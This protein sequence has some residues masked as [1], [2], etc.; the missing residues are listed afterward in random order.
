[1]GRR[2]APSGALTPTLASR[3][4]TAAGLLG[5]FLA[6]L[7]FFPY[8][9]WTALIASAVALAA[10]EWGA[11]AGAAAV[12]RLVYAL[13]IGALVALLGWTGA[14]PGSPIPWAV[15][16]AATLFWLVA[17]PA[18]F[19]RGWPRLPLPVLLGAGAL[20]LVPAGVAAVVLRGGSPAELL[21]VLAAVWVADSAAYLVGR[22]W[23][24]RKLAP[25]ISPG[26]TW[27]GL[28]GALVA[29]ALGAI[30]VQT[31][32]AVRVFWA[33]GLWITLLLVALAAVSVLGDLFESAVKRHA[34][35][36]DSGTLLP[37]HGGVLDR[38]DSLT[39]AL[40]VAGLLAGLARPIGGP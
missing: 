11:L 23:G 25:V 40:P 24:R 29:V 28:M 5:L 16:T 37:G 17:V 14:G 10:W 4:L 9:A 3:V 27:E 38:V 13:G 26:K 8:P 12:S 36:K 2:P 31:A 33:E 32:G 20:V 35:V 21:L 30:L 1:M 39:A 15:F 7:F 34:G 18:W 6:A 19:A 22:R